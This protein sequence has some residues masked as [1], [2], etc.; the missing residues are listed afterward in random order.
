MRSI[1]VEIIVLAD[2]TVGPIRILEG[3]DPGLDQKAIAAARQWRFRPGTVDGEPVAVIAEIV[4][5]FRL[6]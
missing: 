5:E 6:L 2:G 4:M 1:A 3:L